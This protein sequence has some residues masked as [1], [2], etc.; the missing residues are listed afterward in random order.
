MPLSLSPSEKQALQRRLA[1][2]TQLTPAEGLVFRLD[3]RAIGWLSMARAQQ[4]LEAW[5]QLQR[6]ED[7]LHWARQGRD[8][9]ALSDEI[10][11]VALKLHEQGLIRGWRNELYRCEAEPLDARRGRALFRLERAAFRFF[12][13]RS[14]AVHVNGWTPE[15]RLVCGRRAMS[16]ATDPGA[17]DNTAAGG[18]G[19]DEA[20]LACA[21]RELMEEAGLSLEHSRRLKW[22]GLIHSRRPEEGGLHDEL[23]HV[24]SLQLP[25]GFEP[26]NS[27][28]EVSEFLS[29]SPAELSSRL[30]EFSPD[31]AAVVCL[32]LL[33]QG[34]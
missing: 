12:G 19:A 10:G 27:D 5:P 17:L 32:D 33:L 13:L 2:A 14:R 11:A 25:A 21:R 4:L 23:L 9:Q 16:K 34:H 28:G 7:G 29:L 8:A 18:L 24:Y 22:R 3:G 26:R 15:G 30:E 31:A 1:A 6:R 20:P